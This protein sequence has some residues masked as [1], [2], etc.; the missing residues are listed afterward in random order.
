MN[1]KKHAIIR[2]LLQPFLD[3]E[4]FVWIVSVFVLRFTREII[5]ILTWT[6]TTN[7]TVQVEITKNVNSFSK[8][9]VGQWG[10]LGGHERNQKK[11]KRNLRNR[12]NRSPLKNPWK[13][14]FLVICCVTWGIFPPVKSLTGCFHHFEFVNNLEFWK[15]SE[16]KRYDIA[17]TFKSGPGQGAGHA[18]LSPPVDAHPLKARLGKFLLGWGCHGNQLQSFRLSLSNLQDMIPFQKGFVSPTFK[19]ISHNYRSGDL[20]EKVRG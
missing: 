5:L 9:G 11:F 16:G 17:S 14:G 19:R 3:L 2:H 7:L 20:C 6:T 18:P 4:L 1:R 8:V 15:K 12:E 10:G 13:I